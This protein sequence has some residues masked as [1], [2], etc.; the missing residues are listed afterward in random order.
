VGEKSVREKINTGASQVLS[1]A[2]NLVREAETLRVEVLKFN[3][4][5]RAT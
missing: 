1:V 5:G 4:A 3:D 2:S